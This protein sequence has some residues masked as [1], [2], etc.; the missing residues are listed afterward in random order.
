[1]CYFIR[2]LS[3]LYIFLFVI[4]FSHELTDWHYVVLSSPAQRCLTFMNRGFAFSLINDY[5][6]GFSLKDPKVGKII[7][8]HYTA[9]AMQLTLTHRISNTN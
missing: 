6:C 7:Q 4:D 9:K 1:M 8:L 5:M 2:Y 3:V